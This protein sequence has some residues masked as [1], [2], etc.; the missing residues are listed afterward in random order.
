MANHAQWLY[1]DNTE[2]VQEEKLIIL[3][4]RSFLSQ[5]VAEKDSHATSCDK[6]YLSLTIPIID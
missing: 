3:T 4:I 1:G 6:L 2:R 5:L